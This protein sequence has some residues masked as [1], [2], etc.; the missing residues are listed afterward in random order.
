MV[1]KLDPVGNGAAGMLQRLEAVSV[2]A[3]LF[4]RADDALDHSVLLRA[5]RRDELLP[6]ACQIFSVLRS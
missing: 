3:L 5:V 1:V 6:R 4:E 2:Y